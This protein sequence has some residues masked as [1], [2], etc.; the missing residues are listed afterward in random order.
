MQRK[1]L[2]TRI[3]SRSSAD[4]AK[5]SSNQST[6]DESN[7]EHSCEITEFNMDKKRNSGRSGAAGAMARQNEEGN[8]TTAKYDQDERFAD[9]QDEFFTGKDEIMLEEGPSRK[10]RKQMEEEGT[11]IAL[12]PNS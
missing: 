11:V 4:A 12:I 1:C 6:E 2:K 9:S 3:Q 8:I 5:K 7:G 10:R